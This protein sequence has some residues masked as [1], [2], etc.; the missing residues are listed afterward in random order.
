MDG[1]LTRHPCW[2]WRVDLLEHGA[3]K[4][5]VTGG[6]GFMGTNLIG[7]LVSRGHEVVNFDIAAPR[8]AS[9]ACHWSQ[10]DLRDAADVLDVVKATEPTVVFHLGARTDLRGRDLRDYSANVQGTANLIAALS[11]LVRPPLTFYAS[12]RLV[13]AIDHRP[14]NVNDYRTSTVYGESKVAMEEMVRRTG[15]SAG[16]WVI[17]R[18]TSI[19][20]PWF[21][22]PFREFFHAVAARRFVH[23]RGHD[24]RKSIGYVRNTDHMLLTLMEKDVRDLDGRTLWLTDYPPV[25]L[26]VWANEVSDAFGRRRPREVPRP[27]LAGFARVGDLLTR[28]GWGS[29]P[30]TTFRLTNMLTD[31]VYDA[32]ETEALVGPLPY[33]M[34][35][36]VRET[37]AWLTREGSGAS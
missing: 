32:R 31:A 26:R 37:V 2:T 29:A 11:T 19:W 27:V 35:D 21:D 3:V 30:L 5:L 14:A 22:T 17:V 16:P 25:P 1:T 10:G 24:P 12:S 6:S 18:P 33:S 20:G 9:Q 28:L 4:V 13:F 7:E 23:V 8:D 15:T 34:A 36:G